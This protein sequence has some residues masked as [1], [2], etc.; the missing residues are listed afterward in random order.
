MI[1]SSKK[2][3]NTQVLQLTHS[4]LEIMVGRSVVVTTGHVD[5]QDWNWGGGSEGQMGNC[6]HGCHSE[7]MEMDR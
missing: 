2:E 6:V 5:V 4:A 1:A 7:A 3:L